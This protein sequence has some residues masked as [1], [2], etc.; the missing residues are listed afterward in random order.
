M[1]TSKFNT[2]SSLNNVF[3]LFAII[4]AAMTFT[5][6]ASEDEPFVAPED[7][8]TDAT[9]TFTYKVPEELFRYAEITVCYNNDEGTDARW[10]PMLDDT[11]TVTY[12]LK[13]FPITAPVIMVFDKTNRPATINVQDWKLEMDVKVVETIGGQTKV[14]T[15]HKT[16]TINGNLGAAISSLQQNVLDRTYAVK[17]ARNGA[18]E[19]T[20]DR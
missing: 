13:K 6:C 3:A 5:A 8:I 4:F 12:D 19:Y 9:V 17:I 1:K 11:F 7:T 14:E 2:A 10:E 16:Y 20:H 18:V 15:N